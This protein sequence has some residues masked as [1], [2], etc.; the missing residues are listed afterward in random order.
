M[1]KFYTASLFSEKEESL[2]A[3]LRIEDALGWRSN[4]RWLIGGEE[5]LTRSEISSLDLVDVK[6]ADCF[7]IMSYPRGTPKPGGGRWVE[8]GYALGLGKRCFVVGPYENVFCHD[9]DVTVYPTVTCLISDL[10]GV[11]F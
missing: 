9:E 2:A 6:E 11:F 10:K 5:G 8:F 1:V 7:I 3:A 4:A